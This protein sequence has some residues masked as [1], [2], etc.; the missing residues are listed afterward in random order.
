MFLLLRSKKSI[1][2]IGREEGESGFS[3]TRIVCNPVQCAREL[4]SRCQC[5]CRLCSVGP[6]P[7]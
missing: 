7:E 2:E 5:D 6:S 1:Q 4:S 3:E